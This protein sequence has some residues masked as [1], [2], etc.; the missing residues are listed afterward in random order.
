MVKSRKYIPHPGD[1][2]YLSFDSL[3]GH[4]QRGRR[5]AFV[6][7]KYLFNK[8]TGFAI[9][10]PVTNTFRNIPFHIKLPDSSRLTGV[11]MVDQVKSVDYRARKITFIEKAE[12]SFLDE[13]LSVLEP[14]IY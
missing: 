10:C 11:T 9:V 7:S 14:C 1:F 6:I 5:P 13:V 12:L 4:E 8:V 3:A 2:V